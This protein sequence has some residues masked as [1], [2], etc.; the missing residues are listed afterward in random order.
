MVAGGRVCGCGLCGRGVESVN[1]AG[2]H[3]SR[4]REFVLHV[5]LMFKYLV[6][7]SLFTV[8]KASKIQ[9]T[10]ICVCLG[11]HMWDLGHHFRFC[12]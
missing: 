3:K 11:Y 4:S 7:V 1:E 9:N 12:F 6:V 8:F 10:T 5:C 2:P